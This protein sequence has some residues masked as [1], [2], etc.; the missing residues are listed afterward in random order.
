MSRAADNPRRIFV[1]SALPYANGSIHL[2]HLV[3]YLQTDMW[4]RFQKLR[5]HEVVYCCADDAHGTPMMVAARKRNMPVE[6]LIAGCRAEHIRDFESFDIHFDSYHTTHSDENRVLTE[7]I[8]R[9]NDE[10]GHIAHKEVELHF[11][12]EDG[13]FLPDR[14][15]RGTCPRCGAE[16]QYGDQCEKCNSPYSPTDLKDAACSICGAAPVIRKS[17]HAF[18]KLGDFHDVLDKWIGRNVNP[19]IARE[20]RSKWLEPGL[21]DWDFTRDAPYFGFEVPDHDDLYFYVWWDAPIGYY[22]S[23]TRYLTERGESLDTWLTDDVEIHHFIGKDVAYH[24]GIYWPAMLSGAGYRLPRLHVHGFLTVNGLKMSKSRGTF[25]NAKTY[26]KLLDPQHLRYY[27]ACKMG[28]DSVDIDLNLDD[29]VTRVNAD[30]VGKLANIPSRSAQMLLKKLDGKTG[31]VTEEGRVVLDRLRE[32]ADRI[33]EFFEGGEFSHVTREVCTL[34]DEVNRH[35]DE[36]KPWQLVKDDP[37]AARDVLTFA[38]NATLILSIYLKPILPRFVSEIENL[39]GTGEL[40]WAD[41]D[42]SIEGGEINNFNHL[43]GR[44]D[45][46]KVKTMVEDT[47]DAG[48]NGEAGKKK[49]PLDEEPL[50]KECTIDDFMRVDLRVGKIVEASFVEGA[51]RLLGLKVDIGGQVR[52]VFAGIRSAYDP[53]DLVGRLVVVAANLK[54][55]KM[56]F[57]LSEGMVLAAGPGGEDI[58]VTSPDSGAKP[59]MRVH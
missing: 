4:V 27:Y 21:R 57:G 12:E 13:M 29:F 46:K 56:K 58:F 36:K 49:T 17:R 44:V 22:A 3:E 15:I 20:L 37:E 50:E 18:F 38:L 45:G 48:E 28:R 19:E 6:E 2:G 9:K 10:N 26:L 5:G 43:V 47:K 14:L 25:I 34:A 7:E 11:C 8:F 23:L 32:A 35:F 52:N 54:P 55:R 41:L 30:L 42:R 33:V 40:T 51:S 16:D 31:R 39:L 1:T 59:G 53:K 24:H